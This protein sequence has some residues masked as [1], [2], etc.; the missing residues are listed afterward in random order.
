LTRVFPDWSR[1]IELRFAAYLPAL[2]WAGF[3]LFLGG[4]SNVPTIHTTLPVDK[5]AH[6]VM[7]GVL[8]ALAAAGWLRV[9]RP[10]WYWPVLFALLVG[11]TDELHQRSVPNRTSDAKDWVMDAAG[12]SCAFALVV[13]RERK[14]SPIA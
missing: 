1:Q 6:F 12:I 4:R 9:R 10:A 7:Y 8:G 3:L 14:R 2:V 13:H 11:V 5:V